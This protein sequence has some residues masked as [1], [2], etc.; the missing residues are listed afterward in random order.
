MASDGW[1]FS[2]DA[3]RLRQGGQRPRCVARLV[4]SSAEIKSEVQQPELT[5]GGAFD[6]RRVLGPRLSRIFCDKIV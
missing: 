3:V 6:E 5:D 4:P 2:G 1:L